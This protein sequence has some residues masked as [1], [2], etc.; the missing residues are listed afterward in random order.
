MPEST[1]DRWLL[2]A[3]GLVGLLIAAVVLNVQSSRR[4]NE[5]AGW[6]AHTHE[7][8][9]TLEQAL[10]HLREAEAIQRTHLIVEGEAVPS[11]FAASIDAARQNVEEAKTL[12][13]DNQEQQARIPEIQARID[14]LAASWTD[15]MVV[16]RERGFDAARQIVAAGTSR[17]MMA[18]LQRQL[19]QMDDTERMLLWDRSEKREQTYRSAVSTGLISGIGAL[20]GVVAFTVLLRRHLAER[21]T[22]AQVIGEQAERLRTTLASIGDAVITT[23]ADRRITNMNAVGESLTGWS[24]KEAIGQPLDAVFRIVNE[25]TRTPTENPATRALTEGVIVGLAN[26]TLLIAR[27]GAERP[28]DDSAAPIRCRERTVVGCVLVFR[29]VSQRRRLEK[30]NANR[31]AAAQLLSSIVE[32]SEDAII[33]K[34]LDGVI[35][36]WNT[37]AERLFGYTARQAVGRHISLLIPADKAAEEDRIIACLKNGQRVEHFETVRLRSDGQ[38]VVV[39]LTISPIRDVAGQVIGAS[40]IVRDITDWKQAE[41]ERQKF[42]TLVENSTDFIGMCDLQGIPFFVNRAGLQIVGLDSIDQA[43]QTPV[44]DFFFPE[45]QPRIT[46][47]FFPAV[48]QN[49]HG[50]IEVRFRHFKTGEARWMA[51]KVIAL[52]DAGG[53]RLAL[54]TVS[55]DVTERRRLEDDLRKLAADLSKADRRKDE[56]LA[57][58]A[59]EL[60]NPLAPIRNA[61]QLIRLSADPAAQDQAQSMMQR[62]LEQMVRLVDDLLDVSRIT[63]GALELRREQVQLSAVVDSAVETSRPA[64]DFMGH[65]L[66]MTLPPHSIILDADPTRLAQVFSNLL[67]NSA[68][69]TNR[70]GRI[71]LT[72]ERQGGG[73][74][75]S[76]KDT[77]VG[78]AADQLPHIFEMFSQ[79]DRSRERSQGGLGIG[80][81]LVKRLVEMHGGRV[82][83]RSEGLDNGSEFT[84]WLPTIV[85][86][87]G[88]PKV[89][90]E[91]EPAVPKSSLRLLIVDD[92]RDSADSLAMLLRLNGNEIR[93][94]YDGTQA[95]E[96]AR[97]FQPDVTLLD[98]G[99]PKLNGYE[100]CR[101]IREQPWGKNMVLIAMTGWGQEEDRRRSEEAGF[102]YHMVKPLDPK[103]LMR[104][105]AEI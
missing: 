89:P 38:P 44:R 101:R 72:A 23:D 6:V 78:L 32:S 71:W 1:S 7:V 103:A 92:N 22:A 75:V 74:V 66:T 3:G 21:L 60:R 86:A 88:R 100:A 62:Q 50:E 25:E 26:H 5:E 102:N 84:V 63:C 80:L 15:T 9:H 51:Y 8:I 83:A 52:T 85:E 43:R 68:K 19:R 82:D 49:G 104:L 93:T 42:V 87:S 27:D 35:Q 95:T 34:S 54:A 105:L 69:Y 30:E 41:A 73:V 53:K 36:S 79:V 70:G 28:I 17:D 20:I 97:D 99:L 47:E 40:K 57:T 11:S 77:G 94:A 64:I 12:T 91:K 65:K 31:L 2:G 45:D 81:S 4:L 18:E 67:T 59:H 55:Q 98:I 24:Q 16:R 96:L 48:L 33:S 39:S 14:S 37:A 90:E 10:G 56:F 58:L 61:L 46:E 29:D 13:A 76:V